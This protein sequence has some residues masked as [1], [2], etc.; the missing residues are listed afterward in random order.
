MH[1][2]IPQRVYVQ[3]QVRVCIASVLRAAPIAADNQATY[4]PAHCKHRRCAP[5]LS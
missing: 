4:L 1:M 2:R 3:V 5:L